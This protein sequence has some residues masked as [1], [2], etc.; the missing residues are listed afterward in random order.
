M[1]N[2]VMVDVGVVLFVFSG[3]DVMCFGIIEVDEFIEV[4]D[5]V[6]IVEEIYGK[7]FVVG[8]VFEDGVDFVGDF[9]KVVEFIYYVGD[10]FF[11][12]LV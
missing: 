9:G 4:G 2:V 3:V 1:M 12:F 8:C 6:V 7:V 11:E 10:D 5:L